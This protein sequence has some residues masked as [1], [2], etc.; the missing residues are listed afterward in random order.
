[1]VL[2]L[3]T[4]GVELAADELLELELFDVTVVAPAAAL[5]AALWLSTAC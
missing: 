2:V 1:V 5:P 3:P 4:N